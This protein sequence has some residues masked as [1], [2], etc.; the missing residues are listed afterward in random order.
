MR[1]E[2]AAKASYLLVYKVMLEF[3]GIKLIQET[4]GHD[5]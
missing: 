1:K 2:A 5:N 3:L 4:V